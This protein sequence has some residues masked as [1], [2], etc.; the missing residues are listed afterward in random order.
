IREV[1]K[2]RLAG[3]QL[4]KYRIQL[5]TG[6]VAIPEGGRR[7]EVAPAADAYD[8]H[9]RSIRQEVCQIGHVVLQE[10]NV[11]KSAREAKRGGAR[12]TIYV[13]RIGKCIFPLPEVPVTQG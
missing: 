6:N 7:Q 2:R 13:Q 11:F 12:V 5:D 8:G 10:I 3:E 9:M 4:Y 1:G